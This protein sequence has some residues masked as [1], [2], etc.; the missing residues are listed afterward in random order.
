MCIAAFPWNLERLLLSWVRLDPT[1]GAEAALPPDTLT[2]ES[3]HRERTA[4]ATSPP[5]CRSCHRK[6]NPPGFAFEHYD[7][8]G[9]WR[10]EDNGQ[11]VDASGTLTLAGG[12]TLTFTDGIDLAHQLA[13]SE[14]VHDGDHGGCRGLR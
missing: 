12:E 6:I 5:V 13:R 14:R 3:T 4:T 11:P 10:A 8:I 7:A 2:A 1:E 9:S